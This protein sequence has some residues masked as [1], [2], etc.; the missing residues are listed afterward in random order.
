MMKT[1]ADAFD[2]ASGLR[3]NQ[4]MKLTVAYGARNLSA[5]R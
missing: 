5:K 4:P 3:S 2:G 1:R